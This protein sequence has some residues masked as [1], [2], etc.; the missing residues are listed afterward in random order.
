MPGQSVCETPERATGDLKEIPLHELCEAARAQ[1]R[2]FVNGLPSEDAAGVELF[3][4][5]IDLDDAQAW[6]AVFELYR[7]LLLAQASRQVIRGLVGEDDAFCVDRAFQRFWRATRQ[8]GMHEFNDLGS[9]L[10]YLKMCLASVLLDE[11]RARKRQACVS[12]DDVPPDAHVSADPATMVVGH[13]AGRDLWLAIDHEL[14]DD[15]ERQV[16]YLS[17]V[18]GLTPREISSRCPERFADITEI[19]RI[20]RN[21]IDRLRRSPEIHAFRD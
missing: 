13:S 5:A 7:G 14:R 1:E 3:R 4:R 19:Y 8:R 12:I 2:N 17:F 11:A 15:A 21:V 18:S 20:K 9:I 16:A 6:A 10:K